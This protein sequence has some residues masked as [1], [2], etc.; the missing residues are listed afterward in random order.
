MHIQVSKTTWKL[1]RE[2]SKPYD[3][4]VHM[5]GSFAFD[6]CLLENH[7]Q[8]C[9]FTSNFTIKLCSKLNI[10]FTKVSWDRV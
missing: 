6:Y 2:V 5:Y 3:K 4:G 9:K 7:R 1:G 10:L 8:S